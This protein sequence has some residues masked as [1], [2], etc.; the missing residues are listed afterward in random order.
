M[1]LCYFFEIIFV[2]N[3]VMIRVETKAEYSVTLLVNFFF[4]FEQLKKGWSGQ[5]ES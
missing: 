2:S 5:D 3:H 1:L 4:I